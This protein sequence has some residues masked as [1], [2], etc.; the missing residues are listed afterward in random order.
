MQEIQNRYFTPAEPDRRLFP[1]AFDRMPFLFNHSLH[2]H[3]LLTVSALGRLAQKMAKEEKP[4]GFFRLANDSKGLVWGTPE[5]QQALADAFQNIDTSRMRVKFS[6]IHSEPGYRELLENC[7]RELAE[8]TCGDLTRS[9]RNGVATVFISSP[10]EVTPFHVDEEANFLL[11]I[12]GTKTIYIFDGNDRELLEWRELE[13]Y[14]RSGRIHLREKFKSRALRFELKP[15]VGV[16]NPVNFPHWVQNGPG[17]SVSLS[18]G[19]TRIENPIDVL[20]VNHY[21]RKAGLSP[22]PPGEVG[23]LDGAK[24]AIARGA[25][26][27]KNVLRSA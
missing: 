9:Y 2:S 1:E 13:E 10:N 27:I 11:Q 14:Y 16:H 12:Y 19:F 15:G 26:S 5:F 24:R 18:L 25:R 21:L 4:R 3:D 22:T 17:V 23:P 7:T 6:S 8:L 20:H